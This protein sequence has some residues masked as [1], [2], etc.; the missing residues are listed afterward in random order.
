MTKYCQLIMNP[1]YF[2]SYLNNLVFLN[3]QVKSKQ[4]EIEVI[5]KTNEEERV[6]LLDEVLVFIILM[7]AMRPNKHSGWCFCNGI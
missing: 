3:I 5:R 4:V 7:T 6:K 2:I 1:A